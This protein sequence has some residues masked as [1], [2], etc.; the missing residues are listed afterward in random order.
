MACSGR[1]AEASEYAAFF[2]L[3]SLDPIEQAAIE[4]ALNLAAGDI[5]AARM[6]VASCDCSLSEGAEYFLRRLNII[7]AAVFRKCPCARV[8]LS[9]DERT[10]YLNWAQER[11]TAIS[12]G[13]LE[14][15]EGETGTEF[16]AVGWAEH[17][18]TEFSRAETIIN[19]M[20][21]YR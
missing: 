9:D 13:T 18:N 3:D 15:C 6:T 7:M 4:S 17:A 12:N 2:C 20:E 10:A 14:L 16:P 19:A 5:H 21:R 8:T 1:Y 11:L